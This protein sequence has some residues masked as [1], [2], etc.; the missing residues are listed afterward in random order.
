MNPNTLTVNLW[1]AQAR[2]DS[3]RPAP[4]SPLMRRLEELGGLIREAP[5]PRDWAA[6]IRAAREGRHA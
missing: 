3:T 1:T 4:P 6:A 5:T 2:L